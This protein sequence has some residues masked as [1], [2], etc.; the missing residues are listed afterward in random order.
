MCV[1]LVTGLFQRGR[2][3]ASIVHLKPGWL[4][5]GQPFFRYWFTNFGIL[6]VLAVGLLVW[7]MVF[8][9]KQEKARDAFA[10][11][12]PSLAVFGVAC[13]VMFAVSYT[14][15][16]TAGTSKGKAKP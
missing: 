7:A 5:D 14:H 16:R 1:S 15:L 12:F 2:S 4:Q 3:A 9:K 11:V 8:Y 10:F 6:P 13:V